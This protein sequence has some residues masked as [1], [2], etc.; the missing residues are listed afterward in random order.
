MNPKIFKAYDIRGIYPQDLNE[1]AA[2]KIGAAFAIFIKKASGKDNPQIVVGRDGRKSSTSLS[3]ELK[4]G[5]IEQGADVID[6]GLSATPTLYFAVSHY[7]SDGGINVTASHNPK[8][9]NG[10]K[11]VR[12]GAIPLSK[13]KGIEEIKEMALAGD[14]AKS[15]KE[16]KIEERSIDAEY[17]SDN[18]VPDDFNFKVV[19]DTGNSVSGVLVPQ[20]LKNVNFI[21]IFSEI[22]GDFPNH[23]PDPAQKENIDALRKKV[24]EEGDDLG[25]GLDGDGDRMIFVDEKGQV[26]PSDF[27]LALAASSMLKND[28]GKKVL[29]DIRSS[30]IVKETIE[31]AGGEAVP[32]KIG[33]SYI[34]ETMREKDIELGGEYTGHYY[35]KNNGDY[36]ETPYFMLFSVMREMKRTGKPLSE[37]ISPFKVYFHSS[38]IA[39]KTEESE[40]IIKRAEEKYKDGKILTV[41]GLRVDFDDWW[42]LLRASNTE[43]ILKLVVEAKTEELMKEKAEEIGKLVY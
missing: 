8:E 19:V 25:I 33:H 21:H 35:H 4:R 39:F 1:D 9:Y 34:K 30:N 41:D 12:E 10:F 43:P 13:E 26:V 3:E 15:E 37:I 5:L 36:F 22:D 40:E 42:F 27:I 29:Y 23:D 2:Y 14:F 32:S 11:M 17:V 6:I 38:E 20:I 24:V 31:K 28:P 18:S 7:K 16:G